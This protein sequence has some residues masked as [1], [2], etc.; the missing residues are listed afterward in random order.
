MEMMEK[1]NIA[2][3]REAHK[4]VTSKTTILADLDAI[5]SN[6]PDA[7]IVRKKVGRNVYYEY[8]DKSFSI[9]NIPLSDD[10]MAK[11]A[12]TLTILSKFEGMPNF[13]WIDDLIDHFKSSLNILTTKQ[14]VV[15]F[16]ENIDLEG[17]NH[18]A[19][20]FTSIV[21][22]QSL[23]IQYQPFDKECKE[24]VLHPYFLKQFNNRWF[25]FGSVDGFDTLS[26]F[27][28]DRIVNID[29]A[30]VKFKPNTQFKFD[31]IFEEAIG[32]SHL[33][34]APQ[35]IQIQ[36]NPGLFPYIKTKPL[37][38]SQRVLEKT[39]NYVI[40]QI[41]VVINRELKQL[42]LSYGAGL[43]V[44]SPRELVQEISTEIAMS[45][46]NYESVQLN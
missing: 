43:T 42:I 35:K 24:Y 17:R 3:E 4:P 40:I 41:E 46:K 21:S 36:V 38:G 5:E 2:L 13:E 20:L 1:C 31:E 19:R 15:A 22:E 7:Q 45:N 33:F 9:Y 8:A 39:D 27:P 34:D 16:D 26:N 25:L 23:K 44:I 18:F 6:Y 11:M 14:S 29:N 37:H 10:E 28:L 30:D 12:Q 32:V